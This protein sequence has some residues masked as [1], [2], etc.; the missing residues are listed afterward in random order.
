MVVLCLR[1]NLQ[2]T[3]LLITLIQQRR[4]TLFTARIKKAGDLF[5][6][7]PNGIFG[8]R[9]SEIFLCRSN[10]AIRVLLSQLYRKR[11]VIFRSYIQWGIGIL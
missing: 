10:A 3:A 6:P 5:D 1:K 4:R 7:I 2:N 11:R 8:Y 9:K